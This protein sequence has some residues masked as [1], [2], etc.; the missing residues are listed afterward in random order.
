MWWSRVSLCALSVTCVVAAV[1]CGSSGFQGQPGDDAL[2]MSFVDFNGD[3][4]VQEDIVGTTFAQVDV[5]ATICDFGAAGIIGDEV[6]ESFT[7]TVANAVFVNNGFADILIDRYTVTIE[8]SHIPSKTVQIAALLPG[9]RC[10]NSATTH[11]SLDNDCGVGGQCGT[12]ETP[13]EISVFDFTI[14]ELIVGDQICPGVDPAT[15][16]PTPGNVL[17]QT[18]QTRITFSGSDET[19]KRFTVTAGLTASF[20]D[21]NNCTTSGAGG[22]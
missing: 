14:K 7:E 17:P 6:F 10:S 2:T 15:G 3:G 9:G 5:C 8:N 1:G 21:A 12:T 18:K 16:L 11:C 20:F 19:G 22:G 13:V 4:I